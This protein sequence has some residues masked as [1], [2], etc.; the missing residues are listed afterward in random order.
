VADNTKIDLFAPQPEQLQSE[1]LTPG[2][3]VYSPGEGVSLA[4]PTGELKEKAEEELARATA[5]K[6]IR[7]D[8]ERK[9]RIA[10]KKK[11]RKRIEDKVGKGNAK[12]ATLALG[13]AEGGDPT[14]LMDYLVGKYD[15]DLKEEI[16]YLKENHATAVYGTEALLT[17]ATLG[18]GK[19]AGKI[20]VKLLGKKTAKN[21]LA[22]N[23]GKVISTT[24]K[25][26]PLTAQDRGIAKGAE[27]VG[28]LLPKAKMMSKVANSGP[29]L[30]AMAKAGMD[31]P[32]Q[33]LASA[34]YSVGAVGKEYNIFDDPTM[35][36]ETLASDIM[37]M[38]LLGTLLP[39]GTSA[40]A[41]WNRAR[42]SLLKQGIPRQKIP[43]DVIAMFKISGD[44]KG[45]MNLLN[46]DKQV[47]GAKELLEVLKTHGVL[48]KWS[49]VKALKRLQEAHVELGDERDSIVKTMDS[50]DHIKQYKSKVTEEVKT[51]I[52][53]GTFVPG[54]EKLESPLIRAN[55]VADDL[56]LGRAEFLA[57][58]VKDEA[59]KL[60]RELGE[61]SS[62]AVSMRADDILRVAKKRERLNSIL[63][64]ESYYPPDKL[65]EVRR[66]KELE[67]STRKMGDGITHA[68]AQALKTKDYADAYTFDPQ[69]GTVIDEHKLARAQLMS[70]HLGESME[71]NVKIMVEAGEMSAN[72][73]ARL[74][75]RYQ[76]INREFHLTLPFKAA[77][78]KKA[79]KAEM[80]GISFGVTKFDL[81]AAAYNPQYLLPRMLAGA[82]QEVASS[83]SM[84]ANAQISLSDK[85][86]KLV[87]SGVIDVVA[88]PFH[89]AKE[90]AQWI[91]ESA[92]GINALKKSIAVSQ[93]KKRHEDNRQG[94]TYDD[95]ETR[96]AEAY[97]QINEWVVRPADSLDK[98]SSNI[99]P[100]FDYDPEIA[101][102]GGIQTQSDMQF[103]QREIMTKNVDY[104]GNPMPTRTEMDNFKKAW[105]VLADP[106]IAIKQAL[107][108]GELDAFSAEVFRKQ[109]PG[110]W[111]FFAQVIMDKVRT[112]DPKGPGLTQGQKISIEN[113]IPGFSFTQ[114]GR[115]VLTAAVLRNAF[116][117]QEKPNGMG[118]DR[119]DVG[120]REMTETQIVELRP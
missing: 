48:P 104:L 46:S 98:L 7:D 85:Y 17:L 101:S 56:M 12:Y 54:A 20:A 66:L 27:F 36:G 97:N 62:K 118:E 76:Q 63:N 34:I 50:A 99:Q 35:T 103:L 19:V 10:T 9:Q 58:E 53:E 4:D 74:I 83:T 116:P 82:A 79:A 119:L 77:I 72:E 93:A 23:V 6:T 59:T 114:S 49:K 22:G 69:K 102:V 86:G 110:T 21:L 115:G 43:K 28:G 80:K 90:T 29:A 39:G 95:E 113:L 68:E 70:K 13:A 73:G 84:M 65:G 112:L 37:F 64:N 38:T 96:Y 78:A 57:N 71:R 92:E 108:T 8:P 105:K 117:P 11:I 18:V 14:G 88:A 42:K 60:I 107:M 52:N 61:E 100:Y 15:Q 1:E 91:G 89:A 109:R 111:K 5:Q 75:K 67:E 24:R 94:V 87:N 45:F 81:L 30:R 41:N 44:T 16:Q 51:G 2:G 26:N 31:L 106:N 3:M 120:G 55:A 32:E 47:E 33:A 25:F 40:L